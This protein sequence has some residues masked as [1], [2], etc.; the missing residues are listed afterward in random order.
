VVRTLPGMPVA[1]VR[2]QHIAENRRRLCIPD[3]SLLETAF[4]APYVR[5]YTDRA[6]PD[7]DDRVRCARGHHRNVPLEIGPH[8]S[9]NH[10][11]IV[12]EPINIGFL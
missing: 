11:Q 1:M 5:I 9:A 7:S 8:T 10:Q 3:D 6:H 4:Q 12:C 2:F